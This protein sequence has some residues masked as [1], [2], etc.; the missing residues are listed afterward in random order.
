MIKAIP[1]GYHSI[2]PY[3]N[4]VAKAIEF[5]KAAFGAIEGYSFFRR[6]C[7]YVCN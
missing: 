4:D 7:D 5:Y 3:L 6:K 1:K 2:S